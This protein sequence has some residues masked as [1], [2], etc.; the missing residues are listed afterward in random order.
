[1]KNLMNETTRQVKL[2]G[3]DIPYLVSKRKVKN[4]RIEIKN[5]QVVIVLPPWMKNEEQL[6]KENAKWI[7]DKYKMIHSVLLNENQTWLF[8]ESWKIEYSLDFT[9]DSSKKIIRFDNSNKTHLKHLKQVFTSRLSKKLE[10]F[11]N[12]YKEKYNLKPKQVRISKPKTQWGSCSKNDSLRF[13]L[14]MCTLPNNLI[15]YVVYHE[16]CHIHH[17]NH[18]ETFKNQI[19]KEFPRFKSLDKK[20]NGYWIRAEKLF[21]SLGLR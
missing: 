1:M 21:V 17:K 12:H 13:N 15:S 16:M 5:N 2:Y 6:V 19:K 18:G 9:L 7:F 10:I 8:G 4:A 3:L 14:R 20:L 11:V